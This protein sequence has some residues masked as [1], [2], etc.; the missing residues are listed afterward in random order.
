MLLPIELFHV[1]VRIH[2]DIS[3]TPRTGADAAGRRRAAAGTGGR[4][5]SF[6]VFRSASPALAS[7]GLCVQHSRLE[8]Q[9]MRNLGRPGRADQLDGCRSW[10][11]PRLGGRRR[12]AP[13][14]LTHLTRPC[15]AC[16]P[17]SI[18][19]LYVARGRRV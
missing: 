7:R 9:T 16:S 5:E 13:H 6:R 18:R 12:T 4:A 15:R 8:P 11:T 3:D 10:R 17:P 19:T 1:C 14:W 2:I